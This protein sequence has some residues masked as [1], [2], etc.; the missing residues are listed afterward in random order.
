LA[1]SL[2]FLKAN[3]DVA[4]RNAAIRQK[5][6]DETALDGRVDGLSL[7]IRVDASAAIGAGHAMRA[8]AIA[9]AWVLAGGRAVCLGNLPPSIMERFVGAGIEVCPLSLSVRPGSD[10]DA[11]HLQNVAKSHQANVILI[12]GY[13][14]HNPYFASL[15]NERLIVAYVDDFMQLD[16]SVD[17]IVDPNVGASSASRGAG[18]TLLAGGMFT[19]LR[20]EF[21]RAAVPERSFDTSQRSLLLTFGASDPA[22]LSVR[23]LRIA[24]AIA[25]RVPLRIT[26]LAGP[27]H[28]E[29]AALEA[30]TSSGAA[31]LVQDTHDVATLFASMD[32]AF[33]AAGSTTFE[34][35]AL[36]VPTLLVQIADNQRAVID[37]MVAA[38]AALRIDLETA[39][40]DAKLEE[41]LEAFVSTNQGTLQAMSATARR[42]VDRHGAARIVRTLGALA[43]QRSQTIKESS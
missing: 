21:A 10:E 40:I 28:P 31:V 8:F 3:P 6:F 41:I 36:G 42:L 33:S 5:A 38:G 2:R 17:V 39:M 30:L 43:V 25:K 20:A 32:L 35:A 18:V 24:L 4:L 26:V 12:D 37:P 11:K 34:L 7:L 15:R 27:M 1:A 22:R 19:P 14:F 16:L 13:T 29:I 23:T 9:E